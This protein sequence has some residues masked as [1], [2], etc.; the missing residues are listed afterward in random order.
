MVMSGGEWESADDP[1]PGNPQ[2]AGETEVL[3]RLFRT[4]RSFVTVITLPP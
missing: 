1:D 2:P 4:R 3:L